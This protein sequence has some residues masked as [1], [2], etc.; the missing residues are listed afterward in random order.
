MHEQR[1][2]LEFRKRYVFVNLY[3]LVEGVIDIEHGDAAKRP[4]A[5]TPVITTNFER[6]TE[7]PDFPEILRPKGLAAVFRQA[8]VWFLEAFA[9]LLIVLRWRD[10]ISGDPWISLMQ[11]G[12][13][14]L[15]LTAAH[16]ALGLFNL[17]ILGGGMFTGAFAPIHFLI[18]LSILYYF[19]GFNLIEFVLVVALN[20][21]IQICIYAILETLRNLGP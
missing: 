2:K 16:T 19:Y 17:A 6:P 9:T 20:I 10:K 1:K 15:L 5:G 13:V 12:A 14:A 3:L 4:T 8:F 7:E 18:L 11:V 21:F